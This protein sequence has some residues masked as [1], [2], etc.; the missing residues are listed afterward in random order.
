MS[1]TRAVRA[2]PAVFRVGFAELIA[3][4][5]EMVVWILSATMPLIMLALWN[6]VVAEAPIA[7]FGPTEI[8]RYFAAALVVRQLTGAWLV[9][10]LNW[11]IR[12]GGLSARLLR[13]INPLVYEGVTMLSAMPLRIA[14]LTPMLAGLVL[15]RPELVIWPGAAALA[16]FVVSVLLA[17][18]LTFLVQG[19]FGMLAFW[20]DQS[21]G[22]FGVWF[23]FWMLLSGYIAPLQMFPEAFQSVLAWLPF[24]GMIAVPVELLG[25]FLTPRDALFDIGV[26]VAWTAILLLVSAVVWRRGIRRYGAFG[27]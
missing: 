18:V 19:L 17:W 9:W 23:T 6:S 26:Q 8:T 5:A 15:W 21:Q 7:G 1:M 22:L 25:G 11:M 10:H 20:T 3:Y 2:M 12:S 4:R 14:V 24:R 27:A 16:L 13:P